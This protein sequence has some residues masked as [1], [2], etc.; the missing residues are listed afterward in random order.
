[1][2]PRACPCRDCEDRT[3]G[4]HDRCPEYQSW[5]EA[6][7]AAVADYRKR[8]TEL[9]WKSSHERYFMRAEHR[10]KMHGHE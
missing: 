5:K 4:C 2:R 1:M 3:R 10:R 8:Y 7:Q 6:H 9:I